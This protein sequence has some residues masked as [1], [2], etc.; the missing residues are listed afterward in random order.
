MTWNMTKVK[1]PIL[2]KALILSFKKD[3]DKSV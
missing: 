1:N 2:K 3:A